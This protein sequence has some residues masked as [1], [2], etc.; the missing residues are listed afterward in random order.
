MVEC[1]GVLTASDNASKLNLQSVYYTYNHSKQQQQKREPSLWI[2]GNINMSKQMH[3]WPQGLC[4]YDA[5][6]YTTT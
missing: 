3:K 1:D 5:Y 4:N 2:T 6:Y